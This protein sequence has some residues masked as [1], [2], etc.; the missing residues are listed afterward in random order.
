MW[1]K[2]ESVLNIQL[3]VNWIHL[4]MS[5]TVSAR[6]AHR[7][8]VLLWMTQHGRAY[9]S[10]PFSTHSKASVG[11]MSYLKWSGFWKSYWLQGR[12][13]DSEIRQR[14]KGEE[15]GVLS[16][17]RGG[18]RNAI[19]RE[20]QCAW[21]KMWSHLKSGMIKVDRNTSEWKLWLEETLHFLFSKWHFGASVMSRKWHKYQGQYPAQ[22]F[23]TT[24][25]LWNTGRGELQYEAFVDS[26]YEKRLTKLLIT[27]LYFDVRC[28][29]WD[30]ADNMYSMGGQLISVFQGRYSYNYQYFKPIHSKNR[31]H[32]KKIIEVKNLKYYKHLWGIWIKTEVFNSTSR[33]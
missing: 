15:R 33:S 21:M 24:V 12:G 6:R 13:G 18:G 11:A 30:K 14:Q 19:E 29:F 1:H 4:H 5:G 23:W 20:I 25:T 16:G 22:I 28:V 17:E 7:L 8:A 10:Q 32:W 3:S 9:W 2:L 26:Q 31:V 27:D